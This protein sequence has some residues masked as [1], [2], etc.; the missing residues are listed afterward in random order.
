MKVLFVGD[1]H[2]KLYMLDDVENLD[3]KYKFDR[4]IFMGDYIDD[5]DTD[6]HDSLKTLDKIFNLKRN[7]NEKYTLLLGNHE[8]SYLGY[9]CSGHCFVL[10]D[11]VKQKLL[12]NYDLLDLCTEVK[13]DDK[14]YVCTHSGLN[15]SYIKVALEEVDKD[16]R[17][18]LDIIKQKKLFE[19][20]NNCSSQRGGR[21]PFSSCL[22]TD[23]QEHLL[24]LDNNYVYE[25][26]K[27]QI[28]GHSPV[29][30]LTNYH[31][32]N[33]WIIY[34]Y[35]FIDTHSTYRDGSPFGD[36]TYLAWIDNEF[37]ELRGD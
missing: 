13:L 9:P 28:M 24:Y 26:T 33:L 20:L 35:W 3:K 36:K 15:I 11:L 7:N 18:A 27:C 29:K 34:D 30:T 32:E 2:N 22:W 37:K 21:Y 8:L 31:E 23:R 4:I 25:D 12:E 14:N 17:K 1:I 6:N 10:E 5:W 19:Y 16:W